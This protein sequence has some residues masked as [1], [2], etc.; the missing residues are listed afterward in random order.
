MKKILLF[1]F[2]VLLCVTVSSFLI[3]DSTSAKPPAVVPTQDVTQS[4]VPYTSAQGWT[5]FVSAVSILIVIVCF[6]LLV[7]KVFG[8]IH[9]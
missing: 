6:L 4:P 5:I 1:V 3:T 9:R 2:L 8:H 7:A